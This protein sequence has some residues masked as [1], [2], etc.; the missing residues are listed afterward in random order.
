MC[1]NTKARQTVT[2]QILMA[3]DSAA[4]TAKINENNIPPFW[5]D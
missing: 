5:N 2:S 1:I 4:Q 3:V